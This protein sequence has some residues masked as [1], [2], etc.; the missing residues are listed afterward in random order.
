MVGSSPFTSR[1][2]DVRRRRRQCRDIE[3]DDVFATRAT[4]VGPNRHA[5]TEEEKPVEDDVLRDDGCPFVV[6]LLVL[7]LL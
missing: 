1:F 4:F 2:D 3:E 5:T 7:L 6:V